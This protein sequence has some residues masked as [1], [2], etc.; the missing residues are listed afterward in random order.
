MIQISE[1]PANK[2]RD[3]NKEMQFCPI[4]CFIIKTITDFGEF[5]L[6]FNFPIYNL[7]AVYW[8]A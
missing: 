7:F 2:L 5:F 1:I 6:S 3:L 4:L 8:T